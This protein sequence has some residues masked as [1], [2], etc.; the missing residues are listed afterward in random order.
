MQVLASAPSDETGLFGLLVGV[1]TALGPIGVGLIVA[2]ETFFPPIPS[3][4]V[5]PLAGFVAAAEGQSLAVV[6]LA[7]TAGSVLGAWALYGLG[8]LMGEDRTIALL[9]R[10]PLVEE[11]DFRTAE[12]WFA[13]HGQ[14]AVLFGRCVPLVRSLVSLPAGVARMPQLRFLAFTAIG[15]AVWNTALC[16]AGYLLG[17]AWDQVAVIVESFSSLVLVVLV[18]VAAVFVAKR[19]QALRG[20]AGHAPDQESPGSTPES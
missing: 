18:G 11:R 19:A 2:L 3:E 13:K 6:I 10:L 9:T 14:W 7:A 1:M 8:R 20:P 4:V 12:A 5:L 15:S 17:D 16:S